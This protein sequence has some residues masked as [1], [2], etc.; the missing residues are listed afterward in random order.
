[1][2]KNEQ[3][4]KEYIC[5]IGERIY[6]RQYVAA[7]DGNISVKLSENEIIITPTGV[8]K[9]FMTPD[10][11]IKV[12]KY[13]NVIEGDL[14]PSSETKMHLQVYEEQPDIGAVVHAHPPYATSFAVA[15]QPLD[16]K[17]LPEAVILLGTV[18]VAEYGTPS[19]KEIPEAVKPYL[20]DNSAVLLENHGVLTWGTD[21]KEAHFRLESLELYAKVAKLSKS[22][23]GE[24][25]LSDE[26]VERLIQLR[27]EL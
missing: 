21:L 2:T 18:P 9:G 23:P 24:K 4:I 1:M 5:Q 16:E 10:M 7:N 3:Q 15:G 26:N 8:S 13:G 22:L 6:D 14:D 11:L 25:E 20:E 19:T 12:D 17:I 27:E